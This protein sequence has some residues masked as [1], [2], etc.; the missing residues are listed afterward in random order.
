MFDSRSYL[1][2][3]LFRRSR[4]ELE[5]KLIHS[6][7]VSPKLMTQPYVCPT[8]GINFVN[9]LHVCPFV[10]VPSHRTVLSYHLQNSFHVPVQNSIFNV[11]NIASMIKRCG[12]S[13]S[14]TVRRAQSFG[15]GPIVVGRKCIR[16]A[17]S[18]FSR[19]GRVHWLKQCC[20]TVFVQILI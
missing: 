13:K 16:T 12:S 15:C 8:N 6:C 7:P 2:F 17:F 14:K 11:R 9:F 4:Q 19:R 10:F 1:F 3:F 20:L 5:V 18:T